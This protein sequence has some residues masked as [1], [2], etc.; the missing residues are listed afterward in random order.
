MLE[1][2]IRSN[3][4]WP[5][6][7][8]SNFAKWPFTM[9]GIEFGGMEGFI[10]GCKVKDKNVQLKIFRLSGHRAMEM[11]RAFA[12]RRTKGQRTLYFLEKPFSRFSPFWK[13]LYQSA[14]YECAIQNL[15]FRQAL[16]A[17]GTKILRHSM[18]D[19]YT[20]ETTILTS[21]EFTEILTKL[22]SDLL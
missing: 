7:A 14:Y 4:P 10:Q 16:Q 19:A 8:L 5:S 3:F 12:D 20:E 13:D 15:G 6:C 18:A 1:L 21:R 9:D 11:G 22:R 17:T 2:E